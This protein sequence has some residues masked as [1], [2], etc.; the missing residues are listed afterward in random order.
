MPESIKRSKIFFTHC[1]YCSNVFNIL[2]G[3]K[4]NGAK[5]DKDKDRWDLLPLSPIQQIVKVLG[6][7]AEKYSDN[8]WQHVDN[9]K[10]RY[11]AAMWRHIYAHKSGEWLDKESGLP[12]L[13][14]AGCCLLFW[15]WF[16]LKER[17]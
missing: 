16:E 14:H 5:N 10:A 11:E 2:K 1:P 4:S 12:H 17:K 3:S 7:G 6:H 9:A 8:N 13:A 15:L